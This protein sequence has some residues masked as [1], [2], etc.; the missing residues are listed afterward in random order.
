MIAAGQQGL[1][2][3]SAELVT[4]ITVQGLVEVVVRPGAKGGAHGTGGT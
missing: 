3:A 2:P 4:H 1:Q